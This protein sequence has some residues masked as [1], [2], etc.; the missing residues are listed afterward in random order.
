LGAAAG[1]AQAAQQHPQQ[2]RRSPSVWR[3][4]VTHV[5]LRGLSVFVFVLL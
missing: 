3:R 5:L 4:C 1:Q 2:Q